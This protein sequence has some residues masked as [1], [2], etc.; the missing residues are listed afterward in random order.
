MAENVE[1]GTPTENGG[2]TVENTVNTQESG[3]KD[4]ERTYSQKEVD[5]MLKGKFTQEQVNEIVEKRLARVKATNNAPQN[6]S[7]S[8]LKNV[9]GELQNLQLKLAGYE[10]EVALSKH[11]IKEDYKDFID[12]KILHMTN[13]DKSYAQALDEFFGNEENKKYLEEEQIAQRPIPRPK[14]T[15]T[16][17][18][19]R[20]VDNDLREAFG[21]RKK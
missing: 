5:E 17:V 20:A 2:E 12:Y 14:N 4:S 16:M 10:K 9:R 7:D 1:N 11:K 8:E 21:L 18:N 19:E 13:K 15:N 3:N 6:T